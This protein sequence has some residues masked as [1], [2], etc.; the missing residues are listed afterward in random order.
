MKEPRLQVFVR[1]CYY[2]RASFHKARFP[3]FSHELCH[4]NLMAT[5]DHT[6]AQFTFFLDTHF[7]A[8][9]DHFIRSEKR[10]PLIEIDAGKE[11]SSFLQMV[12]HVMAQGFSDETILYFLEDDYLHKEGWVNVLQEGLSLSQ[13][14]YVTLFDDRDKYLLPQYEKAT[15]R[16]FYTP[17]CHWR[18]T[19]STTNSY[20]MRFG[21]LKQH[22]SVH[23]NYSLNREISADYDKFCA[24]S[25]LGATLISPLPGW[26]THVDPDHA[27]PC[28]DWGKYLKK[29]K[30]TR[31][32]SLFTSSVE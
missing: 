17:T 15:F 21:T 31:F 18:T 10:Y 2:S 3:Q 8:D 27:S 29:K 28:S 14:D 23:R 5:A 9:Q 20:A 16:L 13:V 4:H 11:A 32:A 26:S 12:D 24:L 30:K 6:K 22:L 25:A 19:P 1:H 7:G